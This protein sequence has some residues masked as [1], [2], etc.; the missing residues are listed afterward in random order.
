MPPP[1]TF[2]IPLPHFPPLTPSNILS[3]FLLSPFAHQGSVN[4]QYAMQSQ[5]STVA[6]THSIDGIEYLLTHHQSPNLFVIVER[7][8]KE[9]KEIDKRWFYIL[10]RVVYQAPSVFEIIA[11]G[12]VR[13]DLDE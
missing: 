3:Y 13:L 4:A 7:E 2:I 11:N 12:L 1:T 8:R 9:G 10:E 5:H 6:P